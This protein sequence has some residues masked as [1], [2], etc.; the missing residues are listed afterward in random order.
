MRISDE[1]R[2]RLLNKA[3]A[4]M[5]SRPPDLVIGDDYVHRWH[6]WPRNML[7]NVY[8]HKFLHSDDDA[9][10]HDHRT[11]NLSVL[12]SGR[13][14]E[15]F[16]APYP[17]DDLGIRETEMVDGKE[18][19]TTYRVERKAGD[20]IARWPWTPHRVE[21]PTGP[22][23]EPVPAVTMF[24]IGPHMRNWGF[25]YVNGWKSW[26]DYMGHGDTTRYGD[27]PNGCG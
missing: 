22:T 13:Y 14:Y 2:F 20:L 25:H 9:A 16:H 21:L 6:V 10:L 17:E 27:R 19:F 15:H 3:T 11:V 23:G 8:I 18:R 26:Q 12:L 1:R 4:I 7:G 5:A 24:V